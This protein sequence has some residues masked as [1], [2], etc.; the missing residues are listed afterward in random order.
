ML[1]NNLK[2]AEI[3]ALESPDR[4]VCGFVYE[5]GYIP[6]TNIAKDPRTFIADPAEVAAALAYQGEP[7]AIFHS[8][9]NGD[10]NPSRA[11]LRLASY[12]NNST[13][14]IGVFVSGKLELKYV[15]NA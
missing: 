1:E 6:L 8:H 11:D 2:D 9:P 15:T 4:E 12:Y 10:S 5:N 7:L 14:I 13:L 3:H